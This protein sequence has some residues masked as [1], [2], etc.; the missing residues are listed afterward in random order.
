M[1]VYVG[2]YLG[3]GPSRPGPFSLWRQLAIV[4]QVRLERKSGRIRHVNV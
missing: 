1:V 4:L 2:I 3:K